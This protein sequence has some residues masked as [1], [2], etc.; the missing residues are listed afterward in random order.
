MTKNIALILLK[1]TNCGDLFHS[2]PQSMNYRFRQ[3][4]KVQNAPLVIPATG[5]RLRAGGIQ[6]FALRGFRTIMTKHKLDFWIPAFAGMTSG[7][8]LRFNAL[9]KPMVLG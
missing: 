7:A 4:V 5:A 2:A 9:P 1:A 3:R 6:T 8:F